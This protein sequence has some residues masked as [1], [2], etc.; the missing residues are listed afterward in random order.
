MLS[1]VSTTPPINCSPV[2]T[3]PPRSCS[4]VSMIPPINFSPVKNSI[5]DRGLFFQQIGR[6]RWY[7]RP[8]KSDTAADGVIGT[9]M[10]SCIPRHP[11]HLDKRSMRPKL[12]QTKMTIFSF[13]H[14]RGLWSG[15]VG[16]LCNFSLR[17]QWHHRRTCLTSA[18][19]DITDLSPSTFS[20]VWQ[21]PTSMASLFL[22][23]AI[24]L[25]P[26]SLSPAIIVHRCRWHR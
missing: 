1:Q 2:S 8:P 9:A 15:C 20:Y 23:P 17:F 3:T 26:V 24:Y 7:L 11:A 6:S 25:L 5:D 10:K 16:C 13:D 22:S 4:P 18:A 12:L 19:R 21:L 14:L